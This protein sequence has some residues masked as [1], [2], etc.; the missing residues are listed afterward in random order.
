MG[1][2]DFSSEM[3]LVH[4]ETLISN[5]IFTNRSDG[6]QVGTKAGRELLLRAAF[7]KNT[8]EDDEAELPL[9][10]LTWTFALVSILILK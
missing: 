10:R 8:E 5:S 9:E 1:C 7:K 4:L 6:F 2:R 3:F